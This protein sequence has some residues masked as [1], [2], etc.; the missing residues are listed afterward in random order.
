MISTAN[1]FKEP[2]ILEDDLVRLEPLEEKHFELL[3]PTAMEPSL[4]LFTVAK[5]NS[6]EAFRKYFDTAMEEKRTKRSYPFAY[7][8]KKENRYVG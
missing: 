5:V 2:I 4:W 3:L 8:N 1:F 7:F 6:P